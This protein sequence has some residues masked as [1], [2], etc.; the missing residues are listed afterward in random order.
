[1]TSRLA[2]WTSSDFPAPVSPV[3]TLSPGPSSTSA[4]STSAQFEI[5]IR[6]SMSKAPAGAPLPSQLGLERAREGTFGILEHPHRGRVEACAHLVAGL[7]V[8]ALLA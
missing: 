4:R 7:E 5:A 1:P 8:D 6:S 2:D 3:T